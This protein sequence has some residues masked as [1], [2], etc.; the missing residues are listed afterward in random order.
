MSWWAPQW[1]PRK[2][3]GQI[4]L[5]GSTA[6][7]ITLFS[8]YFPQSLQVQEKE[9]ITHGFLSAGNAFHSIA[10]SREREKPSKDL[11]Q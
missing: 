4:L 2:E 8:R 11:S 5:Q 1:E 9:K 7:P 6:G 10:F 3:D